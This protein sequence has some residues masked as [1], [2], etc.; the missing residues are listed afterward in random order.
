MSE[1]LKESVLREWWFRP[2]S[3]MLVY[4]GHMRGNHC[5]YTSPTRITMTWRHMSIMA[6]QITINST[7]FSTGYSNWEQNGQQSAS[8]Y[9]YCQVIWSLLVQIM[10]CRLFGTKPLSKPML[11]IVDWALRNKIQWN[12]QNPKLFIHVNASENTVCEMA[13]IL[14]RG[15]W[16]LTGTMSNKNPG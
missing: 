3:F 2:L 4:T 14:P 8:L 5:A 1:K 6:C 13:A 16:F 15:G 9:A 12:Y 7:V 11:V 10:A